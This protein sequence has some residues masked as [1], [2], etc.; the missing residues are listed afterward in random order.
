MDKG[1][2]VNQPNPGDLVIFWRDSPNSWKGHVGIFLGFD[3]ETKT[4]ITLGGNQDD[5]VKI[6]KYPIN[7]VLGYRSVL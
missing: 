5:R 4:V 6:K 1:V 3:E 2:K 7:Q